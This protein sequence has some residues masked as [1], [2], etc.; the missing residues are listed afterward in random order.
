MVNC[1]LACEQNYMDFTLVGFEPSTLGILDRDT[2]IVHYLNWSLRLITESTISTFFRL[3]NSS[4][5]NIGF[6]CSAQVHHAVMLMALQHYYPWS[7]GL[8]AIGHYWQMSKTSLLTCCIST[9]ENLSL[10][11]HRSCEITMKE[12]N[13][14]VI[15]SC[16]LSDAWFRDLKFYTLRSQNQL[17]ENYFFLENCSTSEGA[18]SHNVLYYQPLPITHYQVMFYANNYFE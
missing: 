5:N 12:K 9:C 7:L 16:V 11:G 3:L 1:L 15:R 2:T 14:L 8:K 10:I 17:V 18:V 6:L 13:T 4:N